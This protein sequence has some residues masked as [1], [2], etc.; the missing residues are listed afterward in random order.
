[1]Q[2]PREELEQERSAGRGKKWSGGE[3]DG[4]SL[5]Q[6]ERISWSECSLHVIDT[7]DQ[8]Y[9]LS[10]GGGVVTGHWVVYRLVH[11]VNLLPTSSN[12]FEPGIDGDESTELSEKLDITAIS[13][14][15]VGGE[16]IVRLQAMSFRQKWRKRR[17]YVIVMS[18]SPCFF[19]P[20]AFIMMT[21]Q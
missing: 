8:L 13:C 17:A 19:S 21:S 11:F 2:N 5:A 18:N 15:I 7:R 1:M 9:R 14:S 10:P 16:E 4:L 3:R 6:I 12:L 20:S